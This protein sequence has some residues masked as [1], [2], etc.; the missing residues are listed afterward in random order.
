MAT[1]ASTSPL[2]TLA[3]RETL[4]FGALTTLL[5]SFGC[6]TSGQTGSPRDGSPDYS[7]PEDFGPA[8]PDGSGTDGGWDDSHFE[9]PLQKTPLLSRISGDHLLVLVPPEEYTGPNSDPRDRGLLIYDVSD[10]TA[11]SLLGELELPGAPLGL[12]VQGTVARALISQSNDAEFD[13]IPSGP[14]PPWVT[15]LYQIDFS[16]PT[17]PVIRSTVE[18]SSSSTAQG[19]SSMTF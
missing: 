17:A 9:L 3:L 19:D 6:S 10:G 16:D 1:R 14:I 2:H 12:W 18:V 15:R 7:S 5:L 4:R 11:P 13:E 8:L